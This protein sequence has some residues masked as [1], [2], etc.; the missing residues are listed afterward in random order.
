MPAPRG[1]CLHGHVNLDRL[2]TRYRGAFL[3][4]AVVSPLL[5]SAALGAFRDS[6]TNA[7]AVLVLVLFVVAMAASG[8]RL[9][10]ILAA[11]SSGAGFDFFL[12]EPYQRFTITDPNDIE[13]AVLLVL[14]GA[15][16]TELA[17]WGRRQ[18]DRAGRR[19]GYLD[20]VLQTAELAAGHATPEDEVISRVGQQIQDVL[21]LDR[22]RYV[23]DPVLAPEAPRINDDGSVTWR[24]GSVDFERDGL[25]VDAETC[26]AVR[27]GGVTRGQYLLTA[28]S[29]VVRPSPEQL[30]V[31]VLLADQLGSILA[32]SPR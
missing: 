4:L 20:G 1:A 6:I 16:V 27:S 28:A 25:P 31:V 8:D 14:V 23:P 32:A 13:A 15:A 29:R 18:Q 11:M 19:S 2:R 3:L 10:G 22:C 26:L 21:D 7:T 24:G 5:L 9:A 12:T 17:L 30:R